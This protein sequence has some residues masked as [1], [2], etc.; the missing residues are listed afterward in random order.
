MFDLTNRIIHK[1]RIWQLIIMISSTFIAIYIPLNIVL[2]ISHGFSLTF[3]YW[4]ITLIFTADIF[5]NYF[6]PPIDVGHQDD[7]KEARSKY[8]KSW[9]VIDLLA[10][11]PFSFIFVAPVL[12]IFKLLKFIRVVQFMSYLRHRAIILGEY[13]VLGFFV[14]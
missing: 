4:L 3:F 11:I 6:S 1:R 10:A 5:I 12:G 2:N 14:F 7:I 13:I 9:F 8:L